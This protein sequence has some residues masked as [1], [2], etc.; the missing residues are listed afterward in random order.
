MEFKEIIE[1]STIEN[2]ILKLPDVQLDRKQY[3]VIAAK[4]EFLGGKWKSNKKGFV[5]DRE[6]PIESLLN[7]ESNKETKKDLQFFPTPNELADY[8]VQLAEVAH[9]HEVLEPSAGRGAICSAI[10]RKSLA[11][12]S[13]Y[14]ISDVNLDYLYKIGFIRI[15]GKDFLKADDK[16]FDRII[17]NPPFS[18]N[19]DIDH[20]LKMYDKLADGGVLVSIASSHW[21]FGKE[22]KCQ[23]FRRFLELTRAEIEDIKSG[24]FKESGTMIGAKIIIIRK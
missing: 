9:G 2:G 13:V 23:E 18:K 15:L 14:E 17:A 24:T 8:L 1:K 11:N 20:I 21:T 16:K 19:Q 5:F 12:I 22:K 6:I 7:S 4:L 3:L 10:R